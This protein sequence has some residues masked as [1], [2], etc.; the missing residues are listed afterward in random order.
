MD[1][2]KSMIKTVTQATLTQKETL[3]GCRLG[4]DSHSDTSCLG[5]HA[6]I[7][8]VVEG[9][10]CEVYPFCN[11]YSPTCDVPVVNGA[12][13]YDDEMG[14]TYILIVNQALYF[15]DKMEHSLLCT[16]QVRNNGLIVD[17]RRVEHD[18]KGDGHTHSIEVPESN[19]IIKLESHG[20]TSFIPVRNPTDEELETLEWIELTSD[21]DWD[22]Y[23][24][25]DNMINIRQ[26]EESQYTP[27]D[28]N[29]L[30]YNIS[31]VL[32]RRVRS[33]VQGASTRS[34]PDLTKEKLASL[35]KIGL[36]T[37]EKTLEATTN[38]CTRE[39]NGPIHS[40]FRRRLRQFKYKQLSAPH[41]EFSSD[42]MFSKVISL[43]GYTCGQV[44]TNDMYFIKFVPMRI[45]SEAP[46]ALKLFIQQVGIPGQMHSDG[47][48][49]MASSEWRNTCTKYDIRRTLTES[50][51]PWQNRAETA[52]RELKK[53]AS[54]LMTSRNAPL[55]VWCY[56]MEYAAELKCLTATKIFIGEG[57][58]PYEMMFGNTPDISEYTSFEWYDYVWYVDPQDGFP[59]QRVHMG[60]WLGVAHNIGQGMCYSILKQNGKVIVRSS[61]TGI[62]SGE[63]NSDDVQKKCKALDEGIKASIGDYNNSIVKGDYVNDECPYTDMLDLEEDVHEVVD[64]HCEHEVD[65]KYVPESV[66]PCIGSR[67]LLSH[68]DR[69]ELGLV[70]RRKRDS[71]GIPIGKTNPGSAFTGFYFTFSNEMVATLY[72]QNIIPEEFRNKYSTE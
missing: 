19:V 1:A 18:W 68:H 66:D 59:H 25:A 57:R 49:E 72:Y 33:I 17:D 34:Y 7:L 23:G 64:A 70:V 11:S 67:I 38:K 37:A 69:D 40:R 65:D 53:S 52:I 35:W 61:V 4:L 31:S 8:E 71:E 15:G 47:A 58:T 36:D 2:T 41:G 22:P 16:N 6:H 63:S 54:L 9:K 29:L 46:Q 5:K 43:R 45:K 30:S 42:T 13:A 56:A 10:L 20:P 21:M 55:R 24:E 51:S 32:Q 28:V 14:N 62:T 3:E 48:K 39:V 12:L 50:H 27:L 44:F 60:R 26:V